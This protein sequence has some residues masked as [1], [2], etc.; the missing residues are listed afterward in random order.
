MLNH[1]MIVACLLT[2]ITLWAQEPNRLSLREVLNQAIERNLDIRLEQVKVDSSSLD[3]QSTRSIYEPQVTGTTQFQSFDAR[4]SNIFEGD[5]A[6]KFTNDQTDLN[7]TLNKSE[8]FGFDWQVQLNNRLSDSSSGTSF[9]ESYSGTWSI[10]FTQKLLRGFGF[11]AEVARKDEFIAR[12][13][14]AVTELDLN[15]GIAQVIQDAE[16][17]YWD[18]VQAIEQLR[19]SENSLKLAKQLYDQNKIKIEVGTLAPIELVNAEATVARREASIVSDENAVRAAEDRLRKIM[20]LPPESWSTRIVP[21]DEPQTTPIDTDLIRDFETALGERSEMRQN[22]IRHENAMLDLK[23]QRNQLLPELNVNGA[24]FLRGT[25]N[26]Q[27]NMQGDVTEDSSYSDVIEQISE[28]DLPGYQ[29]SLNLT[30]YPFNKAAKINKAKAEVSLRTQEL[31][32]QQLRLRLLEEVRGAIRELETAEKSIKANEK[33]RNFAE[34]NL[35]AE[36][37]KFQNGLTTNYRVAEVQDELAQ[38]INEE[39]QARITYRKAVVAYYKAMGTL[40]QE[41]QINLP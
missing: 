9:G 14:L 31:E 41:R 1:R 30:W 11:D 18:L 13:T 39:I 15:L 12:G 3:F 22:A 33:A 28:Q 27:I 24:Y 37:Q 38:R 5:P 4:P 7:V 26:P 35:R 8:E 20:N 32:T 29:V 25:S 23:F 6:E 17:A 34:E 36:Q 16:N 19:V 21:L 2:C 10:G 40:L